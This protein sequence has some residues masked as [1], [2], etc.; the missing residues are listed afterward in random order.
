MTY[1]RILW[2]KLGIRIHC[3]VFTTQNSSGTFAENGNLVFDEH[4]W[5][6]I[7]DKFS[8]A[9]IVEEETP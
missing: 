8:R 5:P 6:D 3:R 7:M 1:I 2:K 4:E 9:Q